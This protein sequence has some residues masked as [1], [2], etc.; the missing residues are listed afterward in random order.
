M[1]FCISFF[2]NQ[3]TKLSTPPICLLLRGRKEGGGASEFP[4]APFEKGGGGFRISSSPLGEGGGL[5]NFL[6]PPS[7]RGGRVL[8]IFSSPLREFFLKPPFKPLLKPPLNSNLRKP[9]FSS[10]PSSPFSSL[11]CS[12][13]PPPPPRDPLTFLEFEFE[14]APP[15]S[16]PLRKIRKDHAPLPSKASK[17]LSSPLKPSKPWLQLI[18]LLVRL[19]SIEAGNAI[20]KAWPGNK[21]RC[22]P[23]SGLRRQ[24]RKTYKPGTTKP[25]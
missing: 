1:L 6:K 18:G 23:T 17:P 10:P 13:P 15:C 22:T 12:P 2:E 5:P 14:E 25:R 11:H 24:P 16:S 8:R 21:P 7:R 4:Q 3:R 19:F 20:L 9:P